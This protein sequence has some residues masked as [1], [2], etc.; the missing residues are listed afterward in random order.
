M[1]RTRDADDQTVLVIDGSLPPKASGPPAHVHFHQREEGI[2]KAGTLGAPAWKKEDPCAVLEGPPSFL[3]ESWIPG[4]T[5]ATISGSCVG[6]QFRRVTWIAT[7]RR[8]LRFSTP[9]RPV[10][11]RFFTWPT[12]CGGIATRNRLRCRHELFSG[13]FFL[14]FFFVGARDGQ[15]PRGYK[16]A[17]L[18]RVVHGGPGSVDCEICATTFLCHV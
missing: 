8:C 16:S 5:Q 17:R 1:R 7:S 13:S 18:A 14:S 10:G 2:V 3:P 6:G 12:C 9:A 15:I 4:G 11:H